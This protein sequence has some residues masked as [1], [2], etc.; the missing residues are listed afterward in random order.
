MLLNSVLPVLLLLGALQR[1]EAEPR[2]D[3]AIKATITGTANVVKQSDKLTA[4]V[5]LVDNMDLPLASGYTVLENMKAAIIYIGSKITIAGKAFTSALNTLAA[6]RSNDV[7]GAFAPVYNAITAMRTLLQSGFTTQFT[8]LQGQGP[9]ITNQLTNAFRSV[10]DHL[11]LFSGALDRMKSGVTAARNAPG[12]PPNGISSANLNR[13]V[14]LKLVT[15]LQDALARLNAD[16]PLILYVVEET[17]RKLSMADAF[18]IEA[19]AEVQ[20]AISDVA[21]ARDVLTSDVESIS[22]N[23]IAPFNDLVAPVYNEQ[24]EMIDSVQ[25]TLE[26]FSTYTDDLAPALGSLALLLD[27]DG[28]TS[29]TSAIEEAFQTYNT[30]VDDSIASSNSVGQYFVDE[31]CQGLRSVIHALIASSPYSNF[32][33]SKFSPRI[34]NQFALSFYTVSECYEFETFR[35]YKLQDLMALIVNMI[36]YDVED[37]GD[38]ISNCALLSDGASCLTLIGPHYEQL[39]TT[40]DEKQEYMVNFIQSETTFSLQR[41]SACVT[42]SKYTTVISVAAIVSNLNTCTQN[43]PTAS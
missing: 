20:T 4:S 29:I 3:F 12:N 16:I 38:A 17:Q 39:A 21:T 15:D 9:F 32:C 10:L 13:Y 22:S 28:I 34:F 26:A 31:T 41:L 33:F 11:T 42:A 30:D 8:A 37:L 7:N 23:I 1:I 5:D 35:L 2:P 24:V 6:D 43:G 40:V 18:F 25:S 36:I 19:E 27:A 14:P